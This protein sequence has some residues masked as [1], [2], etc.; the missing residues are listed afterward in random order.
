MASAA[1][2]PSLGQCW[3]RQ[4]GEA[5]WPTSLLDGWMGP[6]LLA[7]AFPPAKRE[8]GGKK[9]NALD[10]AVDIKVYSFYTCR[11]TLTHKH[12]CL[13]QSQAKLIQLQPTRQDHSVGRSRVMWYILLRSIYQFDNNVKLGPVFIWYT[14]T[15]LATFLWFRSLR[16]LS[17]TRADDNNY[18]VIRCWCMHNCIA[19]KWA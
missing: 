1:R 7:S 16:R 12:I 18:H 4:S 9:V 3:E 19:H 13:L 10:C 17:R 15:F 14:T 2:K 11:H 5:S 8:N 6:G